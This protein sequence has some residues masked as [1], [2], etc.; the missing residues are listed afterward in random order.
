MSFFKLGLRII[1]L[2]FG[3]LLIVFVAQFV[4]LRSLNISKSVSAQTISV[5]AK[6]L[7]KKVENSHV[8]R[9]IQTSILSP[10]LMISLKPTTIPIEISASV[11]P[12]SIPEPIST[13]NS[14][15]D[16]INEYRLTKGRSQISPGGSTC[17]FATTRASEISSD[18]SHNGF[19]SRRDSGSLPY[20]SY[21]N[22]VENIAMTSDGNS[23]VEMWKA[24]PTHDA[25][26]Q[27]DI[28]YGCIANSGSYFVFEGLK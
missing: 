7:N 20:P 12:T 23:A 21:S 15:I 19:T 3:V 18:F 22:V 26:L 5:K 6:Q 11:A 17:D 4:R 10:T 9:V 8:A 13:G 25:N 2:T 27:S 16:S 14:L 28:T 1:I 24:S